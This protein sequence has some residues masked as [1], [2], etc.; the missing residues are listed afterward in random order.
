MTDHDITTAVR[1][2]LAR[3]RWLDRL[4][5]VAII[6]LLLLAA[7]G[8]LSLTA[9][10]DK[11]GALIGGAMFCADVWAAWYVWPRRR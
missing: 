5:R 2:C 11:P 10:F 4:A 8:V 7:L 3:R 1:N 9:L 6:S